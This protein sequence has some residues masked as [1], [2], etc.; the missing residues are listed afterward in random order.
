MKGD[1]VTVA[2]TATRLDTGAGSGMG[3]AAVLVRNRGAVTVDLG[4]PGVTGGAGFGLDAGESVTLD[5]LAGD[6]L[7]GIVASG[8]CVV[9]VLQV[10]G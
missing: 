6:G 8:T 9:H 5:S 7:Y 4:G 10:G 1:R 3:H 2:T